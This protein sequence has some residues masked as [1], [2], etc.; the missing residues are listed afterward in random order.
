[1][2]R[3]RDAS[4]LRQTAQSRGVFQF[5]ILI[6][7]VAAAQNCGSNPRS[8]GCPTNAVDPPLMTL[9]V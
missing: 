9:A 7:S 2:R 3:T 5:E 8:S 4:R 6:A 1:M